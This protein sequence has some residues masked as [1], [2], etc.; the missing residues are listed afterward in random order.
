VIAIEA[1]GEGPPLVLLHG[2]GTSRAVWRRA[3]PELA[4]RRR[5]LTLDLPGFGDSPWERR[6]YELDAV[7]QAI[8]AA[9]A[10]G[11][12][13]PFDLLG[14]S[15]GGAIALLLA[16]RSPELV[17][18]LVLAA[19]AG[20]APRGPL[21]AR[22]AGAVAGP[23]LARRHLL[24]AASG[25]ATARLLLLGPAVDDPRGL[26]AEDARLMLRACRGAGR[27]SEALAAV[28]RADLRPELERLHAPLGLIWGERDRMVP[29]ATLETI[30]RLAP[31]RPVV[32]RIAGAGHVPQ[33]ERP[34]Q[35]AAAV[36][37][38]LARLVTD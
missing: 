31:R 3:L 32:E 13:P 38:V 15:L 33:V 16:R 20:F 27:L 5:V 6:G 4:A 10:E 29:I 12:K 28:L 11:A 22:A 19:P 36:E 24:E 7:A 21:L 8:A 23:V 14:T 35:F 25:S 34:V 1:S 18:R 9:L 37:R 17:R 30:V 2:I 26:P